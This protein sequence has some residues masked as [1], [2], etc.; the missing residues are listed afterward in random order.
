LKKA[1]NKLILMTGSRRFLLD[2][3]I[4]SAWLENDTNIA[5]KLKKPNKFSFR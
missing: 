4:V 2:T 3:N 5:A 1:V